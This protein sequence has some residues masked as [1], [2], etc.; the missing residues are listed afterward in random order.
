MFEYGMDILRADFH[1]HTKQDKEFVYDGSDYISDYINALDKCGINVGVITNHNKFDL[2]EYKELKKASKKKN[3]FILPGVEL[4]VRQGANAVHTLLVFN[5]EHWLANGENHISKVIDSFFL[6]IDSA[7]DKNTSTNKDLM[8]CIQELNSMGKD[9]FIIFAHVEQKRGF[10]EECKGGLIKSLA[11][12]GEF[13]ERVLGFQKLRTRDLQ[14][15]AKEW[16][17][18]EVAL[19]EG[20]DP[21]KIEEI[22]K[23]AKFTFVKIGEYSFNAIKYALKDYKNRIYDKRP[24]IKHG[25]IKSM[26]CLGGRLDGKELLVS[27]AL[28]TLIGIRGSGKSSILEVMR[29]A[30]DIEPMTDIEYKKSLVETVL[31]SGGQI[32]LSVVDRNGKEYQIKRILNESIS[33]VDSENNILSIHVNSVLNNPLYFGQKDLALT[34]AGYEMDLLNKLVKKEDDNFSEDIKKLVDKLGDSLKNLLSVSDIPKQIS[35][36]NEKSI[37]IEHKLKIYKEKGID[38]KLKKQTACNNDLAK[39]DLACKNTQKIISLLEKTYNENEIENISLA[40]YQSQFNQDIFQEA[41]V[42]T[43]KLVELFGSTKEVINQLKKNL[44][45]LSMVKEKLHSR[46]ESFKEE[47]AQVKREINDDTIDLDNYVTCQKVLTSNRNEIVSLNKIL[48]N[49]TRLETKVKEL[50]DNRNEMLNNRYR[51]YETAIK[52][53]N[54]SQDQLNISIEFKGNKE[55]FRDDL[56]KAFKGTGISEVKYKEISEQFSDFVAIIEDYFLDNGKKLKGMVTDGIWAKISDKIEK[57]YL[58]Y[59]K[60]N[61]PDL[62][63]I[64]Y[65]N[66]LLSKHSVGQRASALILFIL[67]QQDSDVIIIDQPEDDLDNQVIYKELIQTIR[68][69]KKDMQFIFATHNA[70]IPVLGDAEKIVTTVYD[71]DNGKIMMDQGS[72]DFNGTHKAIVEIMEGGEEAFRRRN[73]IYTLW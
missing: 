24:Q 18:Y 62:I 57:N 23:G 14:K 71:G 6:G 36:I 4:S 21:K 39:L 68:E 52:R 66:K 32:I 69:K 8:G 47:F 9:Y 33:I 54:E 3:I 50:I 20:S 44:E 60:L 45:K 73:E 19:V 58:D 38:A 65:H 72:I 35:N 46:I 15:K 7:E 22:G 63:K 43:D 28:N 26:K 2:N 41:T 5:P 64:L 29:Y 59:I 1:L 42:Y 10:L 56:Q 40:K 16:M 31:G 27:T 55:V 51:K 53:I 34:R 49:K 25:Y 67:T 12:K 70:N 17:G 37:E 61:C 11:Q 48:E 13:K 30:L